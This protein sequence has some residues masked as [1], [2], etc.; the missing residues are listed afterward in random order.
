MKLHV[1]ED[2]ID[3]EIIKENFHTLVNINEKL[4]KSWFYDT[5]DK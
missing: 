3:E 5:L 1:N 4:K 2:V